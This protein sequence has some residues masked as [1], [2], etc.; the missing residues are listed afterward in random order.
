MSRPRRGKPK[1]A[2]IEVARFARMTELKEVEHRIAESNLRIER[3]RQLIEKLAFEGRDISSAKI[4][5][6]SL[7]VTLSLHLQHR[8]RLHVLVGTKVA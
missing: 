7:C 4:V 3:Q 6:D 8:C 1:V 5:Y 2:F